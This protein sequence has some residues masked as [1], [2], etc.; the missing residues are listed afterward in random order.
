[1]AAMIPAVINVS[2]TGKITALFSGRAAAQIG[3]VI[4][5]CRGIWIVRV[6]G[7][8]IAAGKSSCPG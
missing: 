1:M 4:M 8:V 6:D 5:R 7:T 2:E 3:A